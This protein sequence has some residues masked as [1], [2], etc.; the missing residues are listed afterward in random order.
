MVVGEV[1][2]SMFAAGLVGANELVVH[3][4]GLY[5]LVVGL[6][7]FDPPCHVEVSQV[8]LFLGR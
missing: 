4:Q 8:V 5:C 3:V 7:V 2:F 1:R 6:T